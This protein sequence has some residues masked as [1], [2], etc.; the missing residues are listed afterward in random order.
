MHER[1]GKIAFF[2]CLCKKFSVMAPQLDREKVVHSFG[3]HNAICPFFIAKKTTHDTI[4]GHDFQIF[5][6]GFNEAVR[7]PT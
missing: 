4:H 5:P 2:Y 3:G 7:Q 6:P 1:A